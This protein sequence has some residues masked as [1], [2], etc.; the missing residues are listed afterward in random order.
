MNRLWNAPE[1]ENEYNAIA[2]QIMT[3]EK[4]GE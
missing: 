3:A 2:S 4:T 1:S